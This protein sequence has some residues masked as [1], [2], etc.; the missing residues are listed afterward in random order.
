[1][2]TVVLFTISCNEDDRILF[3]PDNQEDTILNVA[4]AT[5]E[6][7]A[8]LA[9]P[10][11][12]SISTDIMIQSSTRTNVD[13]TFNIN[14]LDDQ[15]DADPIY[16]DLPSSVTIPA[17]E[18]VGTFTVNGQ[19]PLGDIISQT[20]TINVTDGEFSEN[21]TINIDVLGPFAGAY[22]LIPLEGRFAGDPANDLSYATE[23]GVDVFIEP[24]SDADGLIQRR[25]QELAFLPQFGD[26][27]GDFFFNIVGDQ[28]V[29]TE[30]V[31]GGEGNNGVG[32][33][34]GAIVSSSVAPDNQ[35]IANLDDDT[36]FQIIFLD[37]FD[38][39]GGCG[40]EPYRVVLELTRI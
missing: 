22:R 40:F 2:V 17:N 36:T 11:N 32:C 6:T 10:I 38:S 25:I 39:D 34:G 3:D 21:F 29:V 12:E 16:F 26:F 13:R 5:S 33:G 1:M 27:V 14:I 9:I 4:T 23:G 28:V 15:S 30:Q 7:M 19:D 20:L 24:I 31:P 35:A 37:G 8:N 18:F